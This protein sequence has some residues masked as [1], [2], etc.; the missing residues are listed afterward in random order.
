[1]TRRWYKLIIFSYLILPNIA[2]AHLGAHSASEVDSSGISPTLDSIFHWV[3][4]ISIGLGGLLVIYS[5]F[6]YLAGRKD[7]KRK[8]EASTALTY[9]IFI[10]SIGLVVGIINLL[11]TYLL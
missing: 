9:A 7:K 5:A 6:L 4:N 3:M 1:M 10:L 8:A 11:A 2:K